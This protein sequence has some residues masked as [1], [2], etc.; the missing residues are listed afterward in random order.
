MSTDPK[1]FD[2]KQLQ[3]LLV[4]LSGK[5]LDQ[6]TAVVTK[7]SADQMDVIHNCLSEFNEITSKISQVNSEVTSITNG[8]DEV[9]RETNFCSEQL[10]IV[11]EKMITL[12]EQFSFI[13]ELSKSISAI[14]DQ[15]NLLALNATIEAARAG[16]HGKGFGVVASEVKELSRS[17]KNTNAKIESKLIEINN[18]I[19]QLSDEVKLSNKKMENS[20]KVVTQTKNGA[21][22]VNEQM[23]KFNNMINYS[24]D[25]FK[26]LDLTSKEVAL[27]LSDLTTI[28]ETFKF[29]VE[30]LKMQSQGQDS[31]DPLDRLDPLV[32]SSS[33]DASNR[34]TQNEPEYTLAADDILISSTDHRGII[35]F[36][37]QTFYKLAQFPMGA[38]VGKPHNVIRHKDM[39]K[40]AFA[41]LWQVVKAGKLWQGYVCNIGFGGRI[42]WVKA[43]VFPCYQHGVITGYL[44]IREKAEP[45]MIEKAKAAYRRLE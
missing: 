36:A 28:G 8:M 11:S 1:D 16:E 19:K 12:E 6:V 21:A 37:N 25:H 3:Q 40:T 32:K 31:L 39:P 41:D 44:S 24:V 5:E 35:T 27:Q 9:S 42:Y 2:Q 14:S 18:S 10:K 38:L 45:Q 15:T 29:L 23:F 17:T 22:N 7:K 20:L 34:F 26:K 13:N 43:T 33:Y 4:R 30:L